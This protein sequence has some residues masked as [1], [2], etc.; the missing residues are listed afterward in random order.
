M[1]AERKGRRV[2]ISLDDIPGDWATFEDYRAWTGLSRNGAYEALRRDPL[3]QH[4]VRMGRLIRIPKR[5]LQQ[6]R[7]GE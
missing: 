4:L 5:V 1:T 3:R 2:R 6:L 7:D